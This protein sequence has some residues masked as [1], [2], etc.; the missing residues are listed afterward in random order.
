MTCI[1]EFPAPSIKLRIFE[2]M[3]L[4]KYRR[5]QAAGCLF[6]NHL[7]PV[8]ASFFFG[9]VLPPL[10]LFSGGT[11]PHHGQGRKDGLLIRLQGKKDWV[12]IWNNSPGKVDEERIK[13]EKGR[14]YLN[15]RVSIIPRISQKGMEI[16]RARVSPLNRPSCFA[17]V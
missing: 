10:E 6:I 2:V 12:E 16:K 13:G 4:A 17:R 11:L 9:H 1:L 7:L 15:K 14:A 8:C 5:A 3:L